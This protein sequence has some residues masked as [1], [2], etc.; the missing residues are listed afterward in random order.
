[1]L[2]AAANEYALET[3]L[4]RSSIA[5]Q[6]IYERGLPTTVAVTISAIMNNASIAALIRYGRRLSRKRMTVMAQ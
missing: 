4:L 2:R 5:L 3:L 6:D 1:M